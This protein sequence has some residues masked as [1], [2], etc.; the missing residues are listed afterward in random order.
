MSKIFS[1]SFTKRYNSFDSLPLIIFI[2]NIR[3]GGVSLAYFVALPHRNNPAQNDVVMSYI[4]NDPVHFFVIIKPRNKPCY[5]AIVLRNDNFIVYGHRKCWSY[6]L[7]HCSKK[8]KPLLTGL[9]FEISC[10][11]NI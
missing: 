8:E 10:F 1:T 6:E 2:L 4:L 9:I 3:E 11:T 5:F 7:F